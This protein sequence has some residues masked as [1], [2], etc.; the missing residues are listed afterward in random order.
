MFSIDS[1]RSGTC[2][3]WWVVVNVRERDSK[4]R[5]IVGHKVL[6]ERDKST[7]R[8]KIKETIEPV[9]QPGK[10]SVVYKHKLVHK[11]KPLVHRH[12]W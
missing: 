3:L 4:G 8:F 6:N 9:V 10:S 1:F 5:F 11:N 7:G 2:F 12:H